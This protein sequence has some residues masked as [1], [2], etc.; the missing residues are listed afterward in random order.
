MWHKW[1]KFK[2]S[3]IKIPISHFHFIKFVLC[4]PVYVILFHEMTWFCFLPA[5]IHFILHGGYFRKAWEMSLYFV[6]QGWHHE[7]KA[8][9]C[10]SPGASSYWQNMAP[11]FRLTVNIYISLWIATNKNRMH[12]CI[13]HTVCHILFTRTT[14]LCC[15]CTRELD[16]VVFCH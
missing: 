11:L 3:N 12:V 4:V 15:T 10:W 7:V 14:W 13:M 8:I 16:F 9:M 1:G 6:H 5:A 2:C